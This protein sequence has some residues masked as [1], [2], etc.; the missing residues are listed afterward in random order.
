[1]D[2]TSICPDGAALQRLA[3]GQLSDQEAAPLEEH[4]A[5][6]PRCAE[7]LQALQLRD[8]LVQGLQGARA[9]PP[10]PEWGRI[11]GLM[12]RLEGLPPPGDPGKDPPASPPGGA[13]TGPDGL[14]QQLGEYRLLREVGRG[15]MGVV[16][17]AVQESLGRHVALKVLPTH[18]LP[19]AERLERFRREARAAALLH[20]TNIVP[21]YAVGCER[22]VHF[23]AMQFIEGQSVAALVRELR[24]L[25]GLKAKDPSTATSSAGPL[26]EDLAS[27][28][29]DPARRGPATPPAAGPSGTPPGS[30][31]TEAAAPPAGLTP[32]PAPGSAA[33]ART[34]AHLGVQA[35]EALDYAHQAGVVHRDIKPGNLLVDGRGTL[36][37]ADF[38]L[39]RGRDD[40]ALTHSGVLLGTPRYMSPEQALGR[41]GVV[42]HRTDI[43]SLGAT[44]Y[45]LL[46]RRPAFTGRTPEEVAGQILGREPVPP[47][48]LDSSV[49]RDLETI[50]LKAM[51]KEPGRRYQTAAA[52]A[53][54]LRRFLAGEPVVARPVGAVE[55]GWRWV[56]RRPTT[57]G[58]LA[59][60]AVAL[61]ALVGGVV[62]GYYSSRLQ[63]ALAQAEQQ[64]G[65]A[66]EA[67]RGE[68][69]QRALAEELAYFIGIDRAYSAWRENNVRRADDLLGAVQPD[70][71]GNWEWRYLHRLCHADL[72]TLQ[73]HTAMIKGVAWSPDGSRLAGAGGG[74][75]EPGKVMVWD[76][77]TGQ[78]VLSLKGHPVPR[79]TALVHSVAWSPDGGRL[80]S[81]S[82]DK[83]VKVW[84]A[85]T[86]QEALTLKGHTD[87]VFGVA[88][89]PDGTRLASASMD[90]TVKIW[91]AQTEQEALLTLK[92]HTRTVAGVAWSP[93][94]TRLASASDDYTVKVWDAKSGQEVLTFKRHTDGVAG[95]AWSPD[96]TRLA[97]SS[98]DKTVKVWDAKT[99]QEALTLTGHTGGVRGV[100]WSPD[101]TRLA[102]ASDDHTVKVWDA[103][104]G[105][106]ALTLKGHTNLVFGVCWSPDGT[107]LA[108]GSWD[109]TEKVWDAKTGQEALTLTGHTSLVNG[110]TWSPDGT[111]LASAS[112][113]QTVKLW[114]AQ[115]GQE[116]LVLKGHRGVAK[117]VC[118]SPDGHRLASASLDGTVK[119]WDAQTGQ[120][121]LPLTGHTGGVNGV[122]WSPDGT[123]LASASKDATVKVWD[124]KTG[125]QL[126]T[127]TGH[128]G[129]V[130]G[131]AFSPDGSRLA[132]ASQDKTVRVWDAN[133]G[134]EQLTLR[135]HTDMVWGVA[136]SPD[137][138]RLASAS[139]D[140]TVKVWD[141]KTGQE[142]RTLKGHTAYVMGVAFSPDGSRL[143]SS[144]SDRTV[145][146][147][148][149]RSGQEA[150]TLQGHRN[151][152]AGVAWSPDGS[153]LASASYDRTVRLWPGRPWPP[154]PD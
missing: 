137:G 105:Q 88:W 54:D 22:G 95:V 35:A 148:D 143:A 91:D 118:W 36:W 140:Q 128:T 129:A 107:R 32:Q 51:A 21:V 30:P 16:Y 139:L 50:V 6:C 70:R 96:G 46:T 138:S 45:E 38:G 42:D 151:F 101:G 120:E 90:Q 89:S 18:A 82:G 62:A 103:K 29:L 94:G 53:A 121:V 152:V 5:R 108:S 106:E 3:L 86:G 136:W 73:G 154:Q 102:S 48:R 130:L 127:L 122:A 146:L 44:L 25:A 65:A 125:Q 60:S 9:A 133:S 28:R 52:L 145:K 141:G 2:P 14:P 72:M 23:Y 34:V 37:V 74:V 98:G 99:G 100:A 93:D 71:R 153:R 15:G 80:A 114:D 81:A 142:L 11:E 109:G 43:Y 79:S 66:E 116:A 41:R 47:R 76:A 10:P 97:S 77:R 49:P 132:S 150:L 56:K 27:G 126:L 40:V 55:R 123:R 64:K 115:T 117:G 31:D 17:E 149:P 67:R 7:T 119:V 68:G 134:Q 110:V 57:A 13:E 111:R 112:D 4:L 63:A 19:A 61:L 69:E 26:A 39:A 24:Q 78:E 58:L 83:T 1:M 92:G 20:H 12:R 33:F 124:A 75:G 87:A 85:Q 8:S 131:V 84:D 59:V 144:S 104:T 135:G 147:W 113:D